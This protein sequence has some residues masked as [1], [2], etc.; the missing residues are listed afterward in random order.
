MTAISTGDHLWTIFT[1]AWNSSL[2]LLDSLMRL[3]FIQEHC[4]M[5]PTP[6]ST[7]S[8]EPN[9]YKLLSCDL[10]WKRKQARSSSVREDSTIL[11]QS[12]PVPVS[13]VN[14]THKWFLWLL[15]LRRL[16]CFT[17]PENLRFHQWG[18]KH[19]ALFTCLSIQSHPQ[20]CHHW[21]RFQYS[22]SHSAVSPMVQFPAVFSSLAFIL[23]KW[24]Q[25]G[26]LS[27][28]CL[29]SSLTK[30]VTRIPSAD[31]GPEFQG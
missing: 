15:L 4:V 3:P 16:K 20:L 13:F 21:N 7:P 19:K 25:K 29:P 1:R 22:A 9:L 28:V 6:L 31:E 5:H 27:L 2:Q 26:L 8:Q 10:P 14:V 12:M 17:C 30:G 24:V 18:I 23:P 11:P